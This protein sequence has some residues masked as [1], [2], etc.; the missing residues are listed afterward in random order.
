[1]SY[2]DI[3]Y[4]PYA[5]EYNFDVLKKEISKTPFTIA[6]DGTSEYMI[7][8]QSG[9]M[10]SAEKCGFNANHAVLVVGYGTDQYAGDYFILKN[11]WG[12]TWG[13]EGY[14]RVAAN[15]QNGN[16]CALVNMVGISIPVFKQ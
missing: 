11:S 4:W 7:S 16:V 8:Y 12:T 9:I 2:I 10:N 15:T 13:E 1:M 5:S 6:M 3:A 14:A